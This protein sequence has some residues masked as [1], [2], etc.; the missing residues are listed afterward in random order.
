MKIAIIGT[1]FV[2][3]S[4]IEATKDFKEIELSIACSLTIEQAKEFADKYQIPEYTDDY[5]SINEVDL[6]YIAVPNSVHNEVVKVFLNKK[7]P[8]ICEKPFMINSKQTEEIIDLARTNNTFIME[9]LVPAYNPCLDKLRNLIKE[10]SP[11]R[12]VM[13]NQSQYSSRYDSYLEGNKPITFN[14]DF[15]NGA[16]MDLGV[17]SLS[18]V[19][20]LF[21]TP[22]NIFSKSQL[23]SSGAD[24]SGT[25]V[26][27]YDGFN[28]VVMYGKAN[29]SFNWNEIA[30]EKG[31]LRLDSASGPSTIEYYGKDKSLI[32][33]ITF[34]D[35]HRMYYSIKAALDALAEGKIETEQYNHKEMISLHKVLT[36]IRYKSN[37][38]F[39][40]L[41]EE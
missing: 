7:I 18:W 9:N 20:L 16:T 27:D 5:S 3:D 1:N 33:T 12:S 36:E 24:V 34:N 28:A 30:G 11:I 26:L 38:K 31:T 40:A 21:G 41:G 8:V 25:S 17:Y 4:F 23:L 14:P 35:K 32:D 13:F 2:S 19:Q 29:S 39:K 22:N 37:I 6:A 15:A 10:I